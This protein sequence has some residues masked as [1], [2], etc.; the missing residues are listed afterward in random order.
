MAHAPCQIV[1]IGRDRREEAVRLL[2]RAFADD[3]LMRYLFAD[4]G[5]AYRACLQDVFGYQCELHWQMGWPLLG[6]VPRSRLAGLIGIV[7]PDDQAQPDSLDALGGELAAR[8]GREASAR[9][10]RYGARTEGC[11]PAEPLCYIRMIGVRPESQGLGYAR[12]LLEVAQRISE[13][14]PASTGVALDT[15]NPTNVAIYERLGYR[16]VGRSKLA[17]ITIFCMFRPDGA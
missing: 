15:E 4:A 11:L 13:R 12:A 1:D 9:L 3:P 17:D 16:V 14:H 6:V 5:G 2:A 8:I 10:E 7:T